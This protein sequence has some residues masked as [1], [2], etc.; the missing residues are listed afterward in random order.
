MIY[1]GE[2]RGHAQVRTVLMRYALPGER[3]EVK[4]VRRA[5][6]VIHACRLRV[7]TPAP[8]RALAPC[9]HFARCRGCQYQY[10]PAGGQIGAKTEILLE[11]LRRID[12]ITWD[13]EISCH[14]AHP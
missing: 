8:E 13:S 4:T 7:V 12:K 1:G 5:K 6:G 2:A 10:F 9:P 14:A 11:T 3:L